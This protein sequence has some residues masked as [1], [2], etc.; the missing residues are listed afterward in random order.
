VVHLAGKDFHFRGKR[1]TAA[2]AKKWLTQV[3]QELD[4]DFA[5]MG[6]LDRQSFLVH[7][8]IARQLG[9]SLAEIE[10]RYRFHI[11]VQDMH[12]LLSGHNQNMQITLNQ[13]AGARE[14]SQEDFQ[15]VVAVFQN[16]HQ[17]LADQLDAADR[18]R[19]PA[20][21]NMTAGER[22]GPFLLSQPLLTVV[23]GHSNSLDGAWIN[24]FLGQ[25]GEVLDKLKRIHFK[26]LGGI[27]ALQEKLA[28]R[29]QASQAAAV[30]N[31]CATSDI[32]QGK[33]SPPEMEIDR[34]D[35]I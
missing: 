25:L 20:M 31:Q 27:L 22:L 21:T 12:K 23:S 24:K 29:W 33:V 19:L 17:G 10:E 34:K 6:K 16:A 8:E 7:A 32:N 11:A 28:E 4:D 13:I 1:G 3:Q 9:E 18:L 30:S 15:A 35:P 2:D 14:L 5:W 26:S